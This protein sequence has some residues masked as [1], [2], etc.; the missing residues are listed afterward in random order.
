MSSMDRIRRETIEQYGDAPA[1]PAEALD[2]VLAICSDLSDDTL[3]VEATN[4]IYG[5]GVRTGLTMGDLRVLR[6]SL[7]TVKAFTCPTCGAP[8]AT[9]GALDFHTDAAH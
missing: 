5:K 2:H 6:D 8:N 1:T 3:M 9:Q 7:P 4:G